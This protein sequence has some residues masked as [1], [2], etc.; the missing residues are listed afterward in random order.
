MTAR[1]LS[2]SFTDDLIGEDSTTTTTNPTPATL[3]RTSSESLLKQLDADRKAKRDRGDLE[4]QGLGSPSPPPTSTT[5]DASPHSKLKPTCLNFDDCE[6]DTKPVQQITAVV[7]E[8]DSLEEGEIPPSS[9]ES[10][11]KDFP[12]FDTTFD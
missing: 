2:E 9:S 8:E 10:S 11:L 5:A 12:I 6:D 4:S 3:V 1:T 7:T